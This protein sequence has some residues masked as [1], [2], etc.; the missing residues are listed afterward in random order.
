[1]NFNLTVKEL[2]IDTFILTGKINNQKIINNLIDFIKDK[3]LERITIAF[4]VQN[5]KSWENISDYKNKVII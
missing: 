5:V 4:N 1:M 3:N 2:I